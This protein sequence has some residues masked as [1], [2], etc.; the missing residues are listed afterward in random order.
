MN[1]ELIRPILTVDIV[2]LTLHE[3]RV[4][5]VVQKRDKPPHAGHFAL[6]GG[7]VRPEEDVSTAA[8]A[9]RVLRDKA[10]LTA[11]LLEQLMTFSGTERDPRG[12]SASVAYYGLL[13][14][15]DVA[16]QVRRNLKMLP[17]DRATGLPFDHD[18][19]VSKALER[20]RRRA[21]YSSLPAFLLPIAF[22]QSALRHAYEA[23]LGRALNDSAFRRKID[24]LRV[25]EPLA[26]NVS[27]ATARPA[28]LYRLGRGHIVE[29]DRTV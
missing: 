29:F 26:G 4:H 13:P 25:I 23:V 2:V 7:Y 8:A 20:C 5:V 16:Q 15:Q 10:G 21:A 12:W 22:T 14:Y 9:A 27:K 28:Q 18:T 3:Q 19:I 1:Q 17:L 6:I 24:E 11:R